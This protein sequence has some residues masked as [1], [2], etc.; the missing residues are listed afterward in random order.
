MTS[1]AFTF[2]EAGD[3]P[4]DATQPFEVQVWRDDQWLLVGGAPDAFHAR[5][6]AQQQM[7]QYGAPYAQVWGPGRGVAW[8]EWQ[9]LDRLPTAAA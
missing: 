4:A 5:Q 9:V 6:L 1:A 7:A 3:P 2:P 8:G